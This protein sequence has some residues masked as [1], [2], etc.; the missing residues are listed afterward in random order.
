MMKYVYSIISKFRI[1]LSSLYH[2]EVKNMV[3]QAITTGAQLLWSGS[4]GCAIVIGS[5]KLCHNGC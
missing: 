4:Y 2:V 3:K 1:N 5:S